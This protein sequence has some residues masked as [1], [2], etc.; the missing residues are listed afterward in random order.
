ML[1]VKPMKQ[2]MSIT[3]IIFTSSAELGLDKDYQKAVH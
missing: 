3:L 2:V 1:S